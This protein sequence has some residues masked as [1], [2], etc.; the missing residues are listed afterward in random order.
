MTLKRY[1]KTVVAFFEGTKRGDDGSEREKKGEK[2]RVMFFIKWKFM[3]EWSWKWNRKSFISSNIY[4]LPFECKICTKC[5]IYI[6]N[7]FICCVCFCGVFI[8]FPFSVYFLSILIAAQQ[9]ISSSIALTCIFTHCDC[10][11]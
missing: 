3:S 5:D 7:L 1:I 2:S 11:I 8:F 4:R 6:L 9:I 10:S